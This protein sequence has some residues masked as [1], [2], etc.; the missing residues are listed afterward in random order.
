MFF[1]GITTHEACIEI[2]LPRRECVSFLLL[3]IFDD[4]GMTLKPDDQRIAFDKSFI[5]PKLEMVWKTNELFAE[6]GTRKMNTNLL[7]WKLSKFT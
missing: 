6:E 4:F 3:I 1:D 5:F 2:K 7:F